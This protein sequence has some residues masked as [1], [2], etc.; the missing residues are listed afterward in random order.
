MSNTARLR[1][2]WMREGATVRGF[3]VLLLLCLASTASA[4][5]RSDIRDDGAYLYGYA[6]PPE[7]V[8]MVMGCHHPSFGGKNP[9]ETGA[10]EMGAMEPYMTRFQFGPDMMPQ[11]VGQTYDAPGR[12]VVRGDITVW[13]DDQGFAL[14]ELLY[15][16]LNSFWT[17][18]LPTK[19][20]LVM[21]LWT[22]QR[23]VYQIGDGPA[24]E[25]PFEGAGAAVQ[26]GSLACIE[27]LEQMG[28]QTPPEILVYFND[29]FE[30]DVGEDVAPPTLDGPMFGLVSEAV[31]AGCSGANP[32][33]GPNYL[34]I[35][36]IDGDGRN[37][38]VVNWHDISCGNQRMMCGASNCSGEVILT[39]E[40]R[41]YEK[42][43]MLGVG[44][45]LIDLD[46]G[47]KGV[48]A[49]Q[50]FSTCGTE[51]ACAQILYWDGSA[52]QVWDQLW[53]QQPQQ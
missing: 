40:G 30:E 5:W 18:D 49:W 19:D 41:R 9:I 39:G 52:L 2:V 47:L 16:E 37:D 53:R 42:N 43:V 32:T 33:Y 23:F 36:D 3:C 1:A 10:H 45:E 13:L 29:G 20:P 44:F 50:G 22:A 27:H 17:L 38:G 31:I 35:G 4:Q 28:M 7:G 14:P 48:A 12:G 34:L 26:A 21:R 46:N 11:T 51:S 24:Y 8:D 25:V 15:D 6:M